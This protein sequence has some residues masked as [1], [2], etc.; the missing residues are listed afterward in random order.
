M[1]T[2]CDCGSGGVAVSVFD[3]RIGIRYFCRYFYVGSLF[4]IGILK[5]RDIGIGI[6]YFAV[7]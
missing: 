3:V 4:G 1:P 2:C 7:V 6:Q 5:Y